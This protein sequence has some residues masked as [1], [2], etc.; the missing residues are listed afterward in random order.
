MK[1]NEITSF[2]YD[3]I[4]E[5]G[6]KDLVAVHADNKW[7]LVDLTGKEITPLKYDE[8]DYF[9][10]GL[11]IVTSNKNKGC[12]N[13]QGKEVIPVKYSRVKHSQTGVIE[14]EIKDEKYLI[15]FFIDAQGREY[16]EQ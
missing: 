9:Q 14:A 10:N 11:S 7:G 3:Q 15:R 2:K 5:C 12:V 1:G 6:R 13:I 8:I 4:K 16:R